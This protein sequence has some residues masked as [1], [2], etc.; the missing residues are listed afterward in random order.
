MK[1]VIIIG[2]GPAGISAALYTVR[3]NFRTL[4]LGDED[5][6][7]IKAEKIDNYYGFSESIS[8]RDLLLAGEKQAERIGASVVSDEVYSIEQGLD[9]FTVKASR[10]TYQAK[11][12]LLATG[13]SRKKIQ[14]QDLDKYEGKGIS[15]CTTCDGFFYR[16]LPVGVVGSGDYAIHE[17][18][19]LE[20]FTKDITIFTNGLNISVKDQETIDKYKI[21]TRKIVKVMGD[22]VIRG[23]IFE[24]G[25]EASIHGLFI[26]GESA[27][28]LDFA[29]KMG[30]LFEGNNIL[31]DKDHKTNIEGLFAAGDVTG[32]FKQISTAVGQG[33]I[34][35][36][37]IIEYLKQKNREKSQKI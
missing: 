2:K 34:A 28:A 9:G 23:V 12:V 4:I 8:G 7:L 26:A 31:V 21:E 30:V 37:K 15:Y 33:A 17:A 16:N 1:D 18:G 25:G 14:I 10:E 27:S 22:D 35:G 13:Q 5:S 29:R 3:G 36:R 6:V 24:D 20:A 11:A 32:G 19:E